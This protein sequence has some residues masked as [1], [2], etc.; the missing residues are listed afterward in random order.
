MDDNVTYIYTV[1]DYYDP[2]IRE[3]QKSGFGDVKKSSGIPFSI[4][5]RDISSEDEL[6][7]LI[8]ER[9]GPA[10]KL[11]K[12]TPSNKDKVFDVEIDTSDHDFDLEDFS[13][14]CFVNYVTVIKY[15]PFLKRVAMWD[16][17]Q[18][19]Q[20]SINNNPVDS[21]MVDSFDF[22]LTEY[23][24]EVLNDLLDESKYE[25]CD[26]CNEKKVEAVNYGTHQ[27]IYYY[28]EYP[29]DLGFDYL[30]NSIGG[31][32]LFPK[33]Y[34]GDRMSTFDEFDSG[35]ELSVY[36]TVPEK[37]GTWIDWADRPSGSV[38]KAVFRDEKFDLNGK[39]IYKRIDE[40]RGMMNELSEDY[41]A[42]ILAMP[43]IDE[44]KAVE[45]M[46]WTKKKDFERYEK[47]AYDVLNSLVWTNDGL[48]KKIKKGLD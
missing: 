37:H 35:F 4:L 39:S 5:T 42:M 43:N 24:K 48:S 26:D 2:E 7:I 12:L 31:L 47:L 33:E 28:L 29:E 10:C 13:D 16:I 32:I 11:G 22:F 1:G 30:F 18:A 19:V 17:G 14:G 44:E 45:V 34:G 6:D 38:G 20:F 27:N 9:Y 23:R 41:R 3:R 21:E 36:V 15:S 46:L 8:K 25:K 40:G